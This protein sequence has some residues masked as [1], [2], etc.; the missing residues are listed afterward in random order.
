M[1]QLTFV[2][3]MNEDA[4]HSVIVEKQMISDEQSQIPDEKRPNFEEFD[5]IDD[6]MIDLIDSISNAKKNINKTIG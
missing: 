6:E 5:E 2:V 3:F 4:Q 1:Y